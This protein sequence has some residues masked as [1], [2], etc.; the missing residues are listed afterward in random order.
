MKVIA[1]NMMDILR[2]TVYILSL[3]YHEI[4]KWIL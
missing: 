1:F 4:E 3:N 2:T